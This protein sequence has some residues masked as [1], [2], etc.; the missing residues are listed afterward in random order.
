MFGGIL[1]TLLDPSI[2]PVVGASGAIFGVLTAFAIHFPNE[3]ICFFFIPGKAR[4]MVMVIALISA[5][6]VALQ[7]MK[8]D[9]GGAGMLSHFGHLAG[10]ISS[11]IYY[12]LIDKYIK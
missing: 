9:I 3:R 4:T 7:A 12:W 10:M 2:V 6:L 1:V 8:V 11:V 5:G